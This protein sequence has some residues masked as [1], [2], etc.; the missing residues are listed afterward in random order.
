MI[1]LVIP[2][3]YY[4]LQDS[5]ASLSIVS[6]SLNGKKCADLEVVKNSWSGD[7]GGLSNQWDKSDVMRSV[8]LEMEAL[9]DDMDVESVSEIICDDVLVI[10]QLEGIYGKEVMKKM[11]MN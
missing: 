1:K 9:V 5:L 8:T 10:D 7:D 2:S 4:F 11:D 6:V 3:S